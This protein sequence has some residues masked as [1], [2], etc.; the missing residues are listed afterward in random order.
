MSAELDTAATNLANAVTAVVGIARTREATLAAREAEWDAREADLAGQVSDL[1]MMLTAEQGEVDRLDQE[2]TD[3]RAKLVTATSSA[4]ALRATIAQLTADLAAA[5]RRIADLE[6]QLNPGPLMGVTVTGPV[7]QTYTDLHPA[8]AVS[9]VYAGAAKTWSAVSQRTAFP[10]SK[11]VVSNTAGLAEADLP[12]LLASI[13]QS[14]RERIVAWV[15]VH[16]PEHPD[17]NLNA[18]AY[19]ARMRRTAPIIRAAGIPVASCVMGFSIQGDKWLEWIDPAVVDILGFDKYNSGNKKTPP[20]Y[21]DP[22]KVVAEAKAQA[23]RFGKPFAFFETG[24]NRFGDAGLR[25]QW[26]AALRAELAKQ[27]AVTAIWFD[28]QSTSGSDWDASLDRASA[29]AWLL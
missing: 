16:E 10:D 1:Q 13:P 6:R 9:R 24:T 20:V 5:R 29:E 14:E 11:L 27:G 17:K 7:R 8:V 23:D 4:D 3:L 21:Q 26:T 25:V 19:K 2:V 22:V 15:D 18:A 28:R 12:A